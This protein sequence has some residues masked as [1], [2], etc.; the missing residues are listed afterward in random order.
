VHTSHAEDIG[1]DV[2]EAH[3]RRPRAKHGD[4]AL[5]YIGDERVELTDE[6][7]RQP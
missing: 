5:D 7:V 3:H 2:E 1:K 4:R 6:D